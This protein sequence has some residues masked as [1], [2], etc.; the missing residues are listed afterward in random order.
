MQNNFIKMTVGLWEYKE[1]ELLLG[2]VE[3]RKTY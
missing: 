3:L 2:G 1:G